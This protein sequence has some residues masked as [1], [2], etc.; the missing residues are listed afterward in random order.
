MRFGLRGSGYR[1]LARAGIARYISAALLAGQSEPP[2]T[3]GDT[4]MGP[5]IGIIGG[6]AIGGYTG[7]MLTKAGHDV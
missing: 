3:T 1:N 4:F 6:G 2:E 7:G 5:R